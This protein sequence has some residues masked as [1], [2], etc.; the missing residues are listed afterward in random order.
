MRTLLLL[1]IVC[2]SATLD[3]R[4]PAPAPLSAAELDAQRGTLRA[5][6]TR[7]ERGGSLNAATRA[8]LDGHP[9]LPWLEYAELRRTL[10]QRSAREIT[11]FRQRHA[12]LGFAEPL[13]QQWLAELARRRDWTAFA[14]VVDPAIDTS[15]DQRCWQFSAQLAK[16]APEPSLLEAIADFWAHGASRAASCDE[17]FAALTQAGGITDALR[18]RRIEAAAEGGNSALMRFVARGLPAAQKAKAEAYADFIAAPPRQALGWTIDDAGRQ[19]VAI[20]L[21][22]LAR[23]DPA[24]AERL[25]GELAVLKLDEVQQGRVLAEAALW[26][27]AS[28]LPNTSRLMAKVPATAFDDR[29]HE[30]RVREALARA[31]WA[32]ALVAVQAM[33]D[34]LRNDPRWRYLHARLLEQTGDRAA[35][36]PRFAELAREP[37][38][39]GFLAA[40]RIK[41]PYALCPQEIDRKAPQRAQV[42]AMPGLR[43]ALELK[44]LDR[45]GWAELEWKHLLASLDDDG[46]RHA[47]ALA[48]AEHWYDR[49]VFSLARPEDQRYYSLRFPFA[50]RATLRREAHRHQLDEAWVT[51]LIRAESAWNPQ[52]RSHANARGLMQLLPG[53]AADTARANRLPWNGAESLYHAQTNIALGTAYLAAMLRRHQD[54]PYLA[55]AAYNAGP[56]PIARW[57]TQRPGMDIDL[58]VETIPYKE[59]REYVGRI[60]AFSVIYDWRLHGEAVPLS[61][62]MRGQSA[63]R[64]PFVCPPPAVDPA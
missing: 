55:T 57:L 32:E 17:A 36:A 34:P 48:V 47:V 41:Q 64:Q 20:G 31:A 58:W 4:T 26:N 50:Q 37:N 27:A 51:A 13:R 30:W 16:G 49:A 52:A 33:P 6:L 43:R 39:H 62:R 5:A 15:E 45:R 18:W 40:D 38:Y 22:R 61:A 59:T 35:A 24:A 7:I 1:L 12:S 42:A 19:M 44:T 8:A 11:A 25:L 21:R 28:Y 9:L 2:V 46:R 54:Q 56:A 53:T 63:A 14:A 23:R 60:M 10:A 29:L 3:A